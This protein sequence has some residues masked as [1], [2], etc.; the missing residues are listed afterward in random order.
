MLSNADN[1]IV[2]VGVALTNMVKGNVSDAPTPPRL[3]LALASRVRLSLLP[4]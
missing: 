4:T 2:R 3:Y 1:G